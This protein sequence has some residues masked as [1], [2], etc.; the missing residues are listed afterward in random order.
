MPF[1]ALQMLGKMLHSPHFKRLGKC[2]VWQQSL[3]T[4]SLDKFEGFHIKQNKVRA[5]DLCYD[6]QMQIDG[7]KELGD[8]T[9]T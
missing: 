8:D 6:K 5:A 9:L 1:D 3:T 7:A 2:Y 4:D